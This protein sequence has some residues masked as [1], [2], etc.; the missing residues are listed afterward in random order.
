MSAPAMK[1]P[2]LPEMRTADLAL[3]SAANLLI[4]SSNSALNSS[5]RE[6]TCSQK[7]IYLGASCFIKDLMVQLQNFTSSD[8]LRKIIALIIINCY[9]NNLFCRF[10]KSATSLL[11]RLI[12][13]TLLQLLYEIFFPVANARVELQVQMGSSIVTKWCNVQLLRLGL[14]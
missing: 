8:N 11:R 9:T 2:G 12:T 4:I 6:F 10:F 1:Q 7:K 14:M 5:P 3:V 13:K